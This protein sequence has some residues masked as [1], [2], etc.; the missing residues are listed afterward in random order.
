MLPRRED[1]GPQLATMGGAERDFDSI[2]AG[3]EAREAG[4]RRGRVPDDLRSWRTTVA[5]DPVIRSSRPTFLSLSQLNPRK[6]DRKPVCEDPDIKRGG[7]GSEK[8]FAVLR[9][10]W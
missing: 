9:P 3:F 1:D 2:D 6:F 4:D 7:L 8:E 5:K 10:T